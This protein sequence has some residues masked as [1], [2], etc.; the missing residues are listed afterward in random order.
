VTVIIQQRVCSLVRYPHSIDTSPGVSWLRP[1]K[2]RP[3]GVVQTNDFSCSEKALALR[4]LNSEVCLA[5]AGRNAV[6]ENEKPSDIGRSMM[7]NNLDQARGAIDNYLQFVERALSSAPL[8]VSDQS[9]AFRSYVERSV[10]ASF[11]LSE[12]LLRARDFQEI[13]KIQTE[14]FQTQLRALSEQSTEPNQPT[15]ETAP[16]ATRT[17]IK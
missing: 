14:F 9:K 15:T 1:R 10:A 12:K 11:K 6:A 3:D 7:I 17:Q 16:G 4:Y 5:H 2:G 8:G 13:I